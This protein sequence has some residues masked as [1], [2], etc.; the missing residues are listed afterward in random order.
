LFVARR[1]RSE[2]TTLILIGDASADLVE[3]MLRSSGRRSIC[4]LLI[5]SYPHIH[6]AHV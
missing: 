6:I 5:S 3:R 1:S 4:T 2:L